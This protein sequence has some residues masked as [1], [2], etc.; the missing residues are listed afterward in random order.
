MGAGLLDKLVLEFPTVFWDKDVDLIEYSDT[1]SESVYWSGT[2]N[3]YKYF[4]LNAL[5]MFNI[6]DEAIE[7]SELTDQEVIDSAMK[8]LKNIYGEIPGH[9]NYLRSNWLQDEETF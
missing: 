3:L 6:G 8:V 5:M 9:I 1:T 7:Y 4:G 2:L